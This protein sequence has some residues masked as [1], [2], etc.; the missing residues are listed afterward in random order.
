MITEIITQ[1]EIYFTY[2]F[3][4]NVSSGLSTGNHVK[5]IF[6]YN[7]LDGAMQSYYFISESDSNVR[8]LSYERIATNYANDALAEDEKTFFESDLFIILVVLLF[9]SIIFLIKFKLYNK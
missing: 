1:D 6:S 5:L 2:T 9:I 7:K 8:K 3:E 4:L